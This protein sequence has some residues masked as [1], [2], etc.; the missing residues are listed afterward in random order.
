[1]GEIETMNEEKERKPE[2][3]VILKEIESSLEKATFSGFERGVFI[4]EVYQ[5]LVKYEDSEIGDW[6]P[7]FREEYEEETK[8]RM[9]KRIEQILATIPEEEN[10]EK[11]EMK[12]G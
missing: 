10:D 7:R 12:N 4:A 8:K 1:M 3:K 5:L 9:K 2:Y 6:R 11:G